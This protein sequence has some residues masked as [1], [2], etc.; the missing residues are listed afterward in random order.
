MLGA[1]VGLAVL[2]GLHAVFFI[3]TQYLQI[4]LDY[5]ALKAGLAHAVRDR[6][7][8]AAAIGGRLAPRSGASS[9]ASGSSLVLGGLAGVARGRSSMPGTTSA[10]HG[11]AAAVAGLGGGLVISPNQTLTLSQVPVQRAGSA[12]GV[13]QTGQRIGSAAGIAITG[14]VF[15]SALA[16]T[17]AGT[18]RPRSST[19]S[20]GS[21]G[22]SSPRSRWRWPTWSLPRGEKAVTIPDTRVGVLC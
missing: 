13:L 15:Y 6:Q 16:S 8:A 21:R 12:G 7:R 22:S 17:G 5:T 19:A 11:R 14:S 2:R 20:W 10:I 3:L 1:R 18:L 9:V 4:G